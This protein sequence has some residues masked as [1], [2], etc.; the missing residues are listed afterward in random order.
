MN[1]LMV[2]IGG[3]AGSVLR[4]LLSGQIQSWWNSKFPLGTLLV[5]V[6][7]GIILILVALFLK[8][9]NSESLYLLLATGFCGGLSTFSTFSYENLQ[10]IQSGNSLMA[11]LNIVISVAAGLLS[12]YIL[13]TA[14]RTV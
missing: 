9:K 3:G 12:M 1:L 11:L 13:Y 14:L 2:F 8:S 5:N 4:Y 10:L 7:A 6:L